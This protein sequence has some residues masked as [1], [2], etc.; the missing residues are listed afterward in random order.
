MFIVETMDFEGYPLT[1]LDLDTP[2]YFTARLNRV[3]GI[4]GNTILS[5]SGIVN[6]IRNRK[7]FLLVL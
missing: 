1:L 2:N 3:V 4:N 7:H 6:I 5:D